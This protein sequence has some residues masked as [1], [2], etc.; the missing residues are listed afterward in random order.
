M[1]APETEKTGQKSARP[2]QAG[3][4]SEWKLHWLKESMTAGIAGMIV[5]V[6]LFLV[7][8]SFLAVETR[9]VT[10]EQVANPE[11]N[12]ALQ[13][14]HQQAFDQRQTV[15]TIAIGLVGVV[16]GYF[17]GRVPVERRAQA[18]ESSART[19]ASAAEAA[20]ASR[21]AARH[22]AD[23]AA[24]QINDVRATVRRMKAAAVQSP[25]VRDVSSTPIEVELTALEDR[26]GWAG[27]E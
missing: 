17:F 13:L 10:A 14:A 6:A 18:A 11:L 8:V 15:L 26:M 2:E 7:I 3:E 25:G 5:L 22:D 9:T 20:I 24:I 4:K 19:N 12:T 16:T 23:S 1:T 27:R 21:D